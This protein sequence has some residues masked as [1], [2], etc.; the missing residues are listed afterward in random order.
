ML[1]VPAFLLPLALFVRQ[2]GI[3]LLVGRLVVVIVPVVLQTQ[4]VGHSDMLL[5]V[6]RPCLV[7]TAVTW[8][9]GRVLL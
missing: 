1:L 6:E 4:A 9:Q 8:L 2:A 5:L 3:V 7:L